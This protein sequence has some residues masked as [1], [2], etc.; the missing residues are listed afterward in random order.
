MNKQAESNPIDAKFKRTML[1][2]KFAIVIFPIA[3]LG[4]IWIL[5]QQYSFTNLVFVLITAF[6]LYS[7]I[8]SYKKFKAYE[9]AAKNQQ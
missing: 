3:L 8:V 6:A 2:L 7:T 1:W 4:Q 5:Y 9:A